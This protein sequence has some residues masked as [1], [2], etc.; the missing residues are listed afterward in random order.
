LQACASALFAQLL[1]GAGVG[2]IPRHH[3]CDHFA[4]GASD[5]ERICAEMAGAIARRYSNR[6]RTFCILFSRRHLHRSQHS[7]QLA[8]VDL[9]ALMKM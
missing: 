9:P 2:Q 6:A 3:W 4:G 5:L 8:I 1:N 7:A